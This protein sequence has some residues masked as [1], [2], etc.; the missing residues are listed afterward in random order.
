MG[1]SGPDP[2]IQPVAKPIAN[3]IEADQFPH[4]DRRED[5]NRSED[6]RQHVPDNDVMVAC[7]ERARSDNE[8]ALPDRENQSSNNPRV[9]RP[10]DVHGNY[11]ALETGADCARDGEREQ[12]ASAAC[13][14]LMPPSFGGT[15][16]LVQTRIDL[17]DT[18]SITSLRSTSF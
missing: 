11:D 7:S 9:T 12:Q 15:V 17:D 1:R 14:R 4:F 5:R 2:R 8:L 16:R 3:Q 10:P 18:Q 6:V 13:P